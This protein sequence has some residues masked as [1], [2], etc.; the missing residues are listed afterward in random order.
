MNRQCSQCCIWLEASAQCVTT[1][2]MQQLLGSPMTRLAQGVGC[3]RSVS[4]L[5]EH[6]GQFDV[7]SIV[8]D[9][10]TPPCQGT[11]HTVLHRVEMQRE[12]LRGKPVT[13]AAVS[14]RP[15]GGMPMRPQTAGRSCKPLAQPTR[16]KFSGKLPTAWETV[17]TTGMTS[18]DRTKRRR[19]M[20]VRYVDMN[21]PLLRQAEIGLDLVFLRTGTVCL[22]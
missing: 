9:R 12:L 14:G 6:Q 10:F 11:P 21:A 22:F 8:G 20:T 5:A 17:T 1:G 2:E 18:G 13:R 4:P 3:R 16:R 7:E 15:I 19:A